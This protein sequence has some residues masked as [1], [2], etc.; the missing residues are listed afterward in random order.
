MTSS[1]SWSWKSPQP[2]ISTIF[3][4]AD[5]GKLL[6]NAKVYLLDSGNLIVGFAHNRY[7]SDAVISD[8]SILW[9]RS[10][11]GGTSWE[12]LAQPP[13][14]F[15]PFES[16]L[17]VPARRL[18]DGT[19]L[20]AGSYGWDN[21]DDTPENRKKLTDQGYYFF[22][23]EE[24]NAKGT[25]SVIGRCW[26]NRSRDGGK[27]WQQKQ[28]ILPRF[29]PHLANYGDPIV[30][31]DG[32]FVLPMWGRFDLKTEPRFV[33]A[34]VLRTRDAGET[35]DIRL[36]A[37]PP[38]DFDL[39]EMSITQAR[40]GALVALIRSTLQRDL[41]TARS[42]DDGA[43]WSAPRDSGLRGSTP[44][45]V[46]TP[47]GTV[48]AVYARRAGHRGGGEF[49]DT[50]IVACASHDHGRTWNLDHQVMIRDG[51]GEWVDGYPCAVALPDNSVYAVYGFNHEA[52]E[53]GGTRFHP[54][55][56]DFGG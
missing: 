10:G 25:I 48:V 39:A 44:W 17:V 29:M 55:H 31:R 46:T 34:I 30:T 41:W 54:H 11:D 38:G 14:G 33:S 16:N 21:H 19:L 6:Q 3:R 1:P 15:A 12:Y 35:W 7:D 8:L 40:D 42:T 53:I 43:T 32:T 37:K 51:Q 5:E 24:G 49:T 52:R 26:M 28:I 22:S 18:P 13:E 50:G 9:Y 27:T 45:L 23:P 20:A 47:D 2:P 56:P 4:R 36:V